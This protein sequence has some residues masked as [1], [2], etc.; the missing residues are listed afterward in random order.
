MRW[1]EGQN[2]GLER[3]LSR[4]HPTESP[5]CPKIKCLFKCPIALCG[6]FCVLVL[7]FFGE[8]GVVCDSFIGCNS[9]IL[10]FTFF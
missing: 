8:E 5:R 3:I 7:G 4:L 1:E 6:A 9:H 2:G 10:R